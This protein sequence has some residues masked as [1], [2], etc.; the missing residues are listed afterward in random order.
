MSY[1]LQ[2]DRIEGLE[3]YMEL[4]LECGYELDMEYKA[5]NL[6][7]GHG[8]GLEYFRNLVRNKFRNGSRIRYRARI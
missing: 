7:Y 1:D 8:L 3:T 4:D 5:H 6:E 2:P